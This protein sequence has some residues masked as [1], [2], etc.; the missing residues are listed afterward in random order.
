M[1]RPALLFVVLLAFAACLFATAVGQSTPLV[2]WEPDSPLIWADFQGVPPPNAA[3]LSEAAMIDMELKFHT[4]HAAKPERGS[5]YAWVGWVTSVIVS[6]TMNPRFSWVLPSKMSADILHHEQ[7]H[8]DL[9]EVYR[10]RIEQELLKIEV[11]G[12]T[13][14]A[15]L[16][17][18]KAE[19]ERVGDGLLDWAKYVNE[20]LFDGETANGQKADVQAQW[21]ENIR[22]WLANPALA[23]TP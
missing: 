23:P 7:L 20:V 3:Q 16:S 21:E 13:A 14:E 5:G 6:N 11:H 22:A 2:P 15:T 4:E 19:V 18:L 10:R 12:P 8:F 17:A 9:N 1:K